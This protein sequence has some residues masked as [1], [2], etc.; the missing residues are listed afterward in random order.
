MGCG[1]IGEFRQPGSSG[2]PG[3]RFLLTMAVDR[4]LNL[5]GPAPSSSRCRDAERVAGLLRSHGYEHGLEIGN[6]WSAQQVRTSL[7]GVVITRPRLDP[8]P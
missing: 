1:R 3:R 2:Q 5:D 8:T 6:Y 4:Y 7:P